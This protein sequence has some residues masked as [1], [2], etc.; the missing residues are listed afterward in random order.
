MK[1]QSDCDGSGGG[2]R[3]CRALPGGCVWHF[4]SPGK[5]ESRRR[6][7]RRRWARSATVLHLYGLG[8]RTARD[9]RPWTLLYAL[10]GTLFWWAVAVSR[11]QLRACFCG[12]G[13]AVVIVAGPYRWIRHPFYAAYGL[14]W[15]AGALATFWW[16]ALL[17]GAAMCGVY[18]KAAQ[19][20][21]AALRQGP[22]GALYREY[23]RATGHFWPAS[24]RGY[25]LG[26]ERISPSDS[27][28]SRYS[29]SPS[30]WR[31]NG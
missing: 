24:W 14:T 23:Q 22:A 21:E 17:A 6:G 3:I 19:R 31:K 4:R 11:R 8:G 27:I 28:S 7:G 15:L 9:G 20:E 13:E 30:R 16:P 10:S 18:W 26:E 12:G 5:V 1:L 29:G 25:S 2:H